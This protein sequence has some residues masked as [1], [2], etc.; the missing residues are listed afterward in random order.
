MDKKPKEVM[1]YFD[2]ECRA[3]FVLDK[4]VFGD[5]R[6]DPADIFRDGEGKYF[7]NKEH[8]SFIR[9]WKEEPIGDD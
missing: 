3:R 9:E 2:N 7:V 1:I 6:S 5:S 8:V 4:V